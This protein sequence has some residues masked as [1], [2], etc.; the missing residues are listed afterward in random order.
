[1]DLALLWVIIAGYLANVALPT[2]W[3]LGAAG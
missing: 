2:S 1:L 3:I